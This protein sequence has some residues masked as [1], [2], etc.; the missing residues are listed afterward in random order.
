MSHK[1]YFNP[2]DNPSRIEEASLAEAEDIFDRKEHL[3][4][5][6]T[7]RDTA[8]RKVQDLEGACDHKFFF[9][10]AGIPYDSRYCAV[11]GGSLGFI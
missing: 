5:L 6:R 9:D 1:F 10:I 3:E 8:I 4:R 7:I 2:D 11:C